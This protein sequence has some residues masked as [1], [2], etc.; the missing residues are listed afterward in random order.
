PLVLAGDY[1]SGRHVCNAHCGIGSV[2]MLAAG[3]CCSIGIDT[4]IF[5]LNIDLDV[6]IDFWINKQGSERG[7]APGSLIKGRDPHKP[8]NTSFSSK[9]P[10]GILAFNSKSNALQS[11]FLAWLIFE[12]LGLEFPLFSP[13]EIH[14]QQHLSPILRF[15]SS[16]ARMNSANSIA[17]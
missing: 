10:V 5:V 12:N 15:G 9:Q 3:T 6:F 1:N 7:V 14:A 4:E 11:S 13:L 16:C 17:A 8:V 2:D